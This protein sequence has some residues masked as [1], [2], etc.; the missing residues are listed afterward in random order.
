MRRNYHGFSLI[1]L[2]VVVAITGILATVAGASIAGQI[3]QQ[4]LSLAQ[5]NVLQ[6]I[7][8]TRQLA[9]SKSRFFT[10]DF[11]TGPTNSI[12]IY[13][14]NAWATATIQQS[15]ILPNNI[16][17]QIAGTGTG[18]VSTTFSTT[19]N[20]RGEIPNAGQM[21]TIYLTKNADNTVYAASDAGRAACA[22]ASNC[23]AVVISTVLGKVRTIQ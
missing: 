10:I 1:E 23:K 8:N 20:F 3:Q 4:N 15:Q 2:L 21:S 11:L 18:A 7:R 17:M 13:D 16:N 22:A 6:A 14:G 19:F 5:Q 9:I 12:R